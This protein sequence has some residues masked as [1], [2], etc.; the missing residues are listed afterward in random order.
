MVLKPLLNFNYLNYLYSHE[1]LHYLNQVEN[2]FNHLN[3]NQKYFHYLLKEI[4]S[5]VVVIK[6]DYLMNLFEV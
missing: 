6:M 2:Y 5:F 1:C 4:E 3:V